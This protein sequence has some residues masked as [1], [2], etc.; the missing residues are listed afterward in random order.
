MS[1]APNVRRAGRVQ[2]VVGPGLRFDERLHDTLQRLKGTTDPDEKKMLV[3]DAIARGR[4]LML[5]L[6]DCER[7]EYKH[8]PHAGLHCY[9]FRERPGDVCAQFSHV[10]SNSNS[11]DCAR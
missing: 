2:R 9:M 5:P 1:N 6:A 3:R 7:C 8:L 4:E 11:T 10:R